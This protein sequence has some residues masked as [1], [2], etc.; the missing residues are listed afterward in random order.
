MAVPEAVLGPRKYAA[1]LVSFVPPLL[2]VHGWV[3]FLT[4][5]A[6]PARQAWLA[7]HRVIPRLYRGALAVGHPVVAGL[8][9]RVRGRAGLLVGGWLY[10]AAIGFQFAIAAVSF[11]IKIWALLDTRR[12]AHSPLVDQ[13]TTVLML[14]IGL[15]LGCW[16]TFMLAPLIH[17]YDSP[18]DPQ[19]GSVL[20]LLYP[21]A[22]GY[23]TVRYRL[24]DATVVIRRSVVY[25]MLAGLITGA[26]ALLLAGANALA[27]QADWTR[28][29]WFSG[30]FMFGGGPPVQPAPRMGAPRGGPHVLPRALRL[31]PDDPGARPLD[32][33]PA[34]PR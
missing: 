4:Y 24:F 20:V 32:G 16:L 33:E 25:T 11:P 12:R 6:N 29:P 8:R 10:P 28:S 9:G 34:R 21:L 1:I 17:Y 5:P 27:A 30:A 19:V 7:K 22:I 14:G 13:Q 3:F 23:A 18:M 31:C 15:G 2:S 26:Y